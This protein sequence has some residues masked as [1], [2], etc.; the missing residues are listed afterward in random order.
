MLIF[1]AGDLEAVAMQMYGVLVAAG[2][3]EDHAI[4]FASFDFEGFDVGP[5]IAVDGPC[6]ELRAVECARIAEGEGEGLFWVRDG[7][8]GSEADVVP[9]CRLWVAPYRFA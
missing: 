1:D 6:V 5:C 4:A 8:V 2:V 7:V 9:L 3:A